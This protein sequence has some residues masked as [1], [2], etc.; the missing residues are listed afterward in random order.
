M[1][2]RTQAAAVSRSY[3]AVPDACTQAVKLLLDCHEKRDRLPDK[4]GPDDVKGSENEPRRKVSI[5]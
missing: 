5:P 4:S 3:N 1:S 2:S